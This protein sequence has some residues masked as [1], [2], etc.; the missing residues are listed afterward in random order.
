MGEGSSS[1]EGKVMVCF[2]QMV[3]CLQR[4]VLEREAVVKR[5]RGSWALW[6]FSF[7]C[8]GRRGLWL[9]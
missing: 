6:R 8:H 9:V 7:S 4:P 2:A 1:V 3:A 5:R